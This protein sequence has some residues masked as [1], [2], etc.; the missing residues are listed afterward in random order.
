VCTLFKLTSMT[1]W[2]LFLA[3]IAI[4]QTDTAT[5]IE[6]PNGT[7]LV[8]IHLGKTVPISAPSGELLLVPEEGPAELVTNKLLEMS[9]TFET[10]K[11]P[12]SNTMPFGSDN[13]YAIDLL[14]PTQNEKGVEKIVKLN[15]D[16]ATTL[17]LSLVRSGLA[18][19]SKCG[20][21]ITLV[22]STALDNY[23]WQ[24]LF[25]K[26]D[27]LEAK[28]NDFATVR[29]HIRGEDESTWKDYRLKSVK[30]GRGSQ[31]AAQKLLRICLTPEESL[32][33]ES[34][35][36]E[37][38]FA[39]NRPPDFTDKVAKKKL[40][41]LAVAANPKNEDTKSP[42]DRVIEQNLDLGIALTSS[43]A[44]EETPATLTTPATSRRERTT[45][46][47]LDVRFAPVLDVLHPKI[48]NNT[49]MHFLTPIYLNA[50]VATGQI[51]KD[52]LSLNRVLIG[53]QGESRYRAVEYYSVGPNPKTDTRSHKVATHRVIYGFTHASDR[54]F[55]Q[56]EITG[57]IEYQPVIWDWNKPINLNY[58][59]NKREEK[60]PGKIGYTFLPKIG[61]EFGR[62]YHRRNPP[63]AIEASNTVRRLY[64]GVDMGLDLTRF[65]TL[66]VSDTL[67]VRGESSQD[68]LKNYFKGGFEAPLGPIF[69]SA[70]HSLFFTFEKGDLA[71]FA[72]PAVNSVKM[73][74]RIQY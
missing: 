56:D 59:V 53:L 23:D 42:D 30:D 36:A 69:G 22:V 61:F 34:F 7:I 17:S 13:S 6:G 74:Y 11:F 60:V 51:V 14:V 65:L 44:G 66:T 9:S 12:F 39:Q 58:T 28:P 2:L 3:T 63:P 47:I 20:D 33:S 55:K 18:V 35:D 73:G 67:Y 46:G 45:R 52:T 15:I 25:R 57:K 27:K 21:G 24:S 4:A 68:R 43:V 70:V 40:A 16:V 49:W 5:V 26:L 72:T 62:T 50:N 29:I 54:D 1:V 31:V 41:G 48:E 10:F 37:V 64:F 32:P 19:Q 8:R 38:L 71:P